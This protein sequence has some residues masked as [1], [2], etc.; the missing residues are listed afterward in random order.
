M[1]D[2]LWKGNAQGWRDWCLI[3]MVINKIPALDPSNRFRF[4]DAAPLEQCLGSTTVSIGPDP[5]D[6]AQA[7]LSCS[8][9]SCVPKGGRGRSRHASGHTLCME[10]LPTYHHS[11]WILLRDN[12]STKAR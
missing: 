8:R 7:N 11:L 5:K 2:D 6:P 1:A 9:K 3:A 4:L 12:W 10:R